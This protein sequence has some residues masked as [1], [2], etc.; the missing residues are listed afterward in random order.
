MGHPLIVPAIGV[1]YGRLVVVSA[2]KEQRGNRRRWVCVCVC[3][4]GARSATRYDGLASGE[5]RS[6]GCFQREQITAL[7]YKHGATLRDAPLYNT[8]ASMRNRCHN[9]ND[10]NWHRYGGRGITICARWESF[11]AFESDMGPRPD[12]MT[13]DRI[14]NDGPYSPENCRWATQTDQIRNSKSPKL[15]VA[16]VAVI[17]RRLLDGERHR[18]IAD[19]F[20]VAEQTIN[21]I[22][23][24]R[25]WRDVAPEA[26]RP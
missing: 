20:G 22:S 25:Y 1:R 12:G 16:K 14:D 26:A 5:V 21:H 3:D 18:A 2:S 17:K 24:G 15:S 11:L 19:D 8:W 13:L 4:C 6:C 7:K 10:L 23:A 9:P